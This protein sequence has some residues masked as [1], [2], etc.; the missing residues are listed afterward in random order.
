M[1]AINKII[2]E[3]F[4]DPNNPKELAAILKSLLDIE[5][6]DSMKKTGV[7][8]L[9]DIILKKYANNEKFVEWCKDYVK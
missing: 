5:S 6:S 4:S 7:D 8:K 9:Y 3:H 1:V 2:L